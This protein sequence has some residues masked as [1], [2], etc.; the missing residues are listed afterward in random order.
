MKAVRNVVVLMLVCVG[1]VAQIHREGV[2]AQEVP[3]AL[4]TV[5]L[6]LIISSSSNFDVV[7]QDLERMIDLFQ[8]GSG[9][10]VTFDVEQAEQQGFSS[11]SIALAEQL[12]TFSNDIVNSA[13]EPYGVTPS[14]DI[15][16]VDIDVQNYPLVANYFNA[17]TNNSNEPII[18]DEEPPPLPPES[19]VQPSSAASEYWCGTWWRPRPNFTQS[20]QARTVSDP[21]ATLR[22][23]GYHAPPTW[24][25]RLQRLGWT[26]DKTY[27]PWL[28]GFRT[29]RDNASIDGKTILEQNYGNGTPPGEPNPEVWRSGPWPYAAWPAYVYWW[30]DRY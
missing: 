24:D 7:S 5:Y 17:A 11:E 4:S 25:A 13:S 16:E 3:D 30:H 15:T 8:G 1:M 23:W 20:R 14:V 19:G 6:P 9:V 12:A 28:C 27:L 18:E 29:F 21:A 2:F 26:R 10:P 22:S